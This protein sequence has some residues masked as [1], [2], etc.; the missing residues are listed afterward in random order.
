MN[1]NDEFSESTHSFPPPH[2]HHFWARPCL[3]PSIHLLLDIDLTKQM[4][5]YDYV[6]VKRLFG[7]PFFLFPDCGRHLQ[8]SWAI[9]CF[10]ILLHDQRVSIWPLFT[11][12]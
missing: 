12:F 3:G 7:F 6:D 11:F 2:T 1:K 9:C 8:A 5:S 4:P 10:E